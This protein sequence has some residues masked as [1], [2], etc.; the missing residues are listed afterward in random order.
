MIAFVLFA[1]VAFGTKLRQEQEDVDDLEIDPDMACPTECDDLYLNGV[2]DT[3]CD[4]ADC[5]FD[6]GDCDDPED[7]LVIEISDT[8]IEMS[9]S[10]DDILGEDEGEE[11]LPGSDSDDD[12]EFFDSMD[13]YDDVTDPAN[14]YPD[15]EDLELDQEDME[16]MEEI[17]CAPGC[18]TQWIG[19]GQCDDECNVDPCDFDDGDCELGLEE[20][21]LE[22]L[23]LEELDGEGEDSTA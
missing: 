23:D 11:E 21:S 18:S 2:C 7:G 5:S 19:D 20:L 1:A 17:D 16:D 10:E 22:D 9:P 3:Q 6:G 12:T 14:T 15:P 4:I 13:A 8:A